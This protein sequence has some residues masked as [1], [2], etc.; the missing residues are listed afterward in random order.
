V[1]PLPLATRPFV[2]FA[3]LLRRHGFAVVTAQTIAFL[4]SIA[5]LGP[6]SLE[7]VYWAARA[8]LAPTVERLDEF[9]ALFEDFFGDEAGFLA[10]GES[11]PDEEVPVREAGRALLDPV[12]AHKANESG[13]SASAAEALAAKDFTAISADARLKEMR[14]KLAVLAPRRRGF[15]RLKSHRGESSMA[16]EDQ[17]S[18]PG[19]RGARNHAGYSCSSIFPDR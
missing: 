15:R 2:E 7:D 11:M 8:T 18:R 10:F 16:K 9:D 12:V 17:R 3:Q 14:R 13:Q 6:R 5:L 19:Q 1:S 4:K